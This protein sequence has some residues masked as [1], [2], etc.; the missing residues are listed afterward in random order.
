[1][2]AL[3]TQRAALVAL[4]AAVP[5][6][7][8]VNDHQP[9]ATQLRDLHNFYVWPGADG[10]T[11]QLRGWHLRRVRTT[12]TEPGVGRTVNAHTWELTG[13]M[14]LDEATDSEIVFDELVEAIRRAYRLDPTLAA[15]APMSPANGAGMQVLRSLPVLFANVLCHSVVM[16]VTTHAYLDSG[17]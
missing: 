5:D 8:V 1:M 4:V 6:V 2:S 11:P 16:Q 15:A 12:E 10:N 17:E 7:G 9:Y 3:A 13:Y 14:A